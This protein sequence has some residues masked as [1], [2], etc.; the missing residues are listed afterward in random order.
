MCFHVVHIVHVWPF[1]FARG[2]PA[3][4]FVDNVDSLDTRFKSARVA[5]STS[6]A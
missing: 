2:I 6:R 4:G 3:R 1:L 5:A